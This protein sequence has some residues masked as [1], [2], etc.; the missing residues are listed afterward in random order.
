VVDGDPVE[1]DGDVVNGG[2]R[3]CWPATR[4]AIGCNL[5]RERQLIRC[6]TWAVMGVDD[7]GNRRQAER[8]AEAGAKAEQSARA[9]SKR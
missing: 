7:G 9:R 3:C 8:Q 1:E 6:S 4:A 5:T 2:S